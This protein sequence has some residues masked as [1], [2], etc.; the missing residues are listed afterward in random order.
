[1]TVDRNEPETTR[2]SEKVSWQD[3]HET[4]ARA[5]EILKIK[6]LG[7]LIES[8]GYSR[9]AHNHWAKEGEAPKVALWAVH[10]YVA[11]THTPT[12]EPTLL[13]S[14]K[15]KLLKLAAD[16]NEMEIVKRLAEML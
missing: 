2:Q 11:V 8:I 16:A 7:D 3:F 14:D 5:C 6:K 13:H 4:A 1:M 15:I 10:G 12:P 9:S